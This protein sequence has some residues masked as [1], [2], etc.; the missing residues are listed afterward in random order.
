MRSWTTLFLL[1]MVN[2][3]TTVSR[4]VTVQVHCACSV[5]LCIALLFPLQDT[6]RFIALAGTEFTGIDAL[7]E[8]VVEPAG[9]VEQ[10]QYR[11]AYEVYQEAPVADAPTVVASPKRRS[12]SPSGR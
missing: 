12:S 6:A 11:N 5:R 1:S 10:S 4:H 2:R 7:P 9:S 8:T 3:R